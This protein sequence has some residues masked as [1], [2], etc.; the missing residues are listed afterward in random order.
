MVIWVG[1]FR[2]KLP[3][4]QYH[5]LS[6]RSTIVSAPADPG[7]RVPNNALTEQLA[8][9]T[10]RYTCTQTATIASRA[11]RPLM[12]SSRA[13]AAPFEQVNISLKGMCD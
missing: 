5:A 4:T 9:L 12:T 8:L 13:R 7:M 3:R 6:F 10:P 1:A 2:K 11:A